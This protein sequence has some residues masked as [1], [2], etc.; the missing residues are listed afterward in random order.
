MELPEL[1]SLSSVPSQHCKQGKDSK[2][3]EIT[4]D[5]P[6]LKTDSAEYKKRADFW[7]RVYKDHPPLLHWKES[8]TFKNTKLYNKKVV[9][10][11]KA[12][13]EL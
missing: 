7:E 1:S 10:D 12:K 11:S 13:E 8:P 5:G 2:H 9:G 4:A 3:L 6:T